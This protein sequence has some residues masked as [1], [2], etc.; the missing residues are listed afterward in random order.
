MPAHVLASLMCTVAWRECLFRMENVKASRLGLQ[1]HLGKTKIKKKL[2]ACEKTQRWAGL[3]KGVARFTEARKT[4]MCSTINEGTAEK[5]S[6]I[7]REY[8]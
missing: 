7:C 2:H 8:F 3:L 1:L 5:K 4:E 6:D